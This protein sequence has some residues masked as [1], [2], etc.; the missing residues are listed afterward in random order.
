MEP[1]IPR[2][3]AQSLAAPRLPVSLWAE[4]EA[5]SPACTSSLEDTERINKHEAR[6]SGDASWDPHDPFPL[7]SSLPLTPSPPPHLLYLLVRAPKAPPPRVSPRVPGAAE[8]PSLG[9]AELRPLSAASRLLSPRLGDLRA[10]H[11]SATARKCL[12]PSPVMGPSSSSK[13]MRTPRPL[14]LLT[15][16]PPPRHREMGTTPYT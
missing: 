13:S 8:S 6:R 2:V 3:L 9:E 16:Q 5:S 15:P 4:S 12:A 14:P 1:A 10:R 11:A 7:N